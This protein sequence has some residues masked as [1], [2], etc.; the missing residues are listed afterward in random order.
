[1]LNVFKSI[2]QKRQL[3]TDAVKRLTWNEYARQHAV[4]WRALLDSRRDEIR[5]LLH[6]KEEAEARRKRPRWA[7][8][9]AE[10]QFYSNVRRSDFLQMFKER[11][12]LDTRR[13]LS[14][15]K[16][17]LLGLVFGQKGSRERRGLT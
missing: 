15:V 4:V 5:R 10:L 1:M 6:G 2:A 14:S 9:L 12:R 17:V 8:F 16:R 11:H 7:T 3:R 13:V